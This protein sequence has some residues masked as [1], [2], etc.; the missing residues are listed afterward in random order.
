MLALADS[1]RF[2]MAFGI[3]AWAVPAVLALRAGLRSPRGARTVWWIVAAAC[4][5]ITTDKA[6]DLQIHAHQLGQALVKAIAPGL[7]HDGGRPWARVALLG[8]LFLIGCGALY[9]LV[10]SD[11]SI[12]GSKRLS[13]L[14][15]VLVMAYLGARLVPRLRDWWTPA[16]GMVVEGTCWLLVVAGP[17]RASRLGRGESRRER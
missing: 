15:L 8:A 13:L 14:G 7:T 11:R 10:R 2:T 16:L 3:A 6:F 1:G 12:D 5:I 4:T 9:G 17:I